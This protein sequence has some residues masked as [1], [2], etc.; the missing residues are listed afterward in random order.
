MILWRFLAL[1]LIVPSLVFAQIG[2]NIPGHILQE[3]T[4]RLPY[5]PNLNFGSG[6]TCVNNASA[7]RI[8][9]TST[10]VSGL[11]VTAGKTLTVSNTMTLTATDSSTVAFG[12]GGTVAYVADKLSVF[13]ATTSA[14]LAS[15]LSDENGTGAFCMTTSCAM[16]TPSLGVA[17]ATSVT[18]ASGAGKFAV[19]SGSLS[20][21]GG[22]ETLLQSTIANL[23]LD[24][25]GAIP[26][27][28]RSNNTYQMDLTAAGHLIFRGSA[29]S[30]AAGAGAC[31]TS[32]A[33]VGNDKA[34][35]VTVGSSMN[36]AVCTLT[37]TASY[38]NAPHCFCTNAT[39]AL[40][41]CNVRATAVDTI[42]LSA[43]TT[44]TAGDVL[45]YAC[46]GHI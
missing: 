22:N 17:S 10:G 45:D 32:P 41:V 44:F 1:L 15:V 3:D 39:S 27:L 31:G 6:I 20:Q 16:V 33:I 9:C 38:D 29:P 5:Q 28:F 25:A 13:A 40:R 12:G 34:G 7:R 14:E 2:P 4:V 35:R 36:G 46:F 18:I 42:V 30:V 21:I 26:I 11:S 24:A 37:L 23:T 43:V 8:D 19:P